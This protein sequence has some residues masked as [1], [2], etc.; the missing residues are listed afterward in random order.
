M[1]DMTEKMTFV[2]GAAINTCADGSTSAAA[3]DNH[4][5]GYP[6]RD[7]P[8]PS[9]VSIISSNSSLPTKVQQLYHVSR[10]RVMRNFSA[11]RPWSEFFDTT[12]FHSPSGVTDTVNRLNRNLPYFYANYLVTSLVCSSY[13]L[14]INLPFAVYVLITTALYLLIRNRSAMVAALAAQGASE[15]EQMVY[16]GGHAFTIM[17]LYLMLGVFGVI[18]FYLTGGSSVIFWLLL[19]S[20]GVSIGHASLRRP[21]IQDSDFDFA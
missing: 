15:E 2:D 5:L 9:Y 1:Q 12:F 13:I 14:L 19:T 6:Q 7:E 20:L 4:P 10:Q 8:L 3:A 17:Q 11:L 21:P 16:F 18:G